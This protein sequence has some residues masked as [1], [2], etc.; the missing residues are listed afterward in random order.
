MTHSPSTSDQRSSL[1]AGLGFEQM[2]QEQIRA[3][4]LYGGRDASAHPVENALCA[5]DFKAQQASNL[6]RAA[7]AFDQLGVRV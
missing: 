2:A 5:V 1:A 7:K 3:L 4:H 6:G